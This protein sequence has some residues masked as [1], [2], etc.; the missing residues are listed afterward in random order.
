MIIFMTIAMIIAMIIV[1][2]N[3]PHPTCK[4]LATVCHTA[5]AL[6]L[7]NLLLSFG[8]VFFLLWIH[9]RAIPAN[10]PLFHGIGMK[11]TAVTTQRFLL[12]GHTTVI[13]VKVAAIVPTRRA[14]NARARIW[15]EM[16]CRAL[17]A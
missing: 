9:R 12:V 17:Q 14:R 3:T 6:R 13:I 10:L 7:P 11:I 1:I 4:F 5:A 16:G 15:H 2:I 8:D